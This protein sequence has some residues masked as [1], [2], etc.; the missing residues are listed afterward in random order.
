MEAWST[1]QS[2]AMNIDEGDLVP[3]VCIKEEGSVSITFVNTLIIKPS[4]A[5]NSVPSEI[6]SDAFYNT[7]WT[8]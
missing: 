4:S 8:M 1:F 3:Y 6:G 2:T 7:H 5:I